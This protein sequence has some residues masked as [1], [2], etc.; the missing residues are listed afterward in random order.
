MQDFPKSA[1]TNTIK[2]AVLKHNFKK[3][4]TNS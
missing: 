1:S 2:V 4:T 3:T